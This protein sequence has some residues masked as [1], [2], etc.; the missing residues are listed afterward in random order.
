MIFS[1]KN[2]F[3]L[4][5]QIRAFI[6]QQFLTYWRMTPLVCMRYEAFSSATFESAFFCCKETK[7]M[8]RQLFTWITSSSHGKDIFNEL[9]T[10]STS[11][12]S[13]IG[14]YTS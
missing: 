3:L 4:S 2:I 8:K 5:C 13:K 6:Q 7:L 14:I 1:G 11:W 12:E 10:F 9:S